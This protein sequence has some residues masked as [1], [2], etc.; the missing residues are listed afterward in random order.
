MKRFASAR[1]PLVAAKHTTPRLVAATASK[2]RGR[3]NVREDSACGERA[4]LTGTARLAGDIRVSLQ[5]CTAPAA[6]VLAGAAPRARSHPS[7]CGGQLYVLQR[8]TSAACWQ[9]PRH[10]CL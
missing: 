1:M 2:R 5:S 3:E 9:G 8:R 7:H 6:S 4:V 10:V